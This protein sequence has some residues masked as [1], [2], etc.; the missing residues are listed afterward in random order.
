MFSFFILPMIA[1]LCNSHIK[2]TLKWCD[3]PHICLVPWLFM[4]CL[5]SFIV[6]YTSY[7]PIPYLWIVC[8]L[9]LLYII[10]TNTSIII[11]GGHFFLSTHCMLGVLLLFKILRNL[12]EFKSFKTSCERI[13]FLIRMS[14]FWRN[15]NFN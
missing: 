2:L 15:F 4:N 7:I 12:I 11:G 8:Y 5:L 6:S 14:F 1:L 13:F 10:Y 3:L 9:C